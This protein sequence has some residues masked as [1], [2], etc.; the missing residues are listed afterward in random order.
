MTSNAAKIATP[1]IGPKCAY[2]AASRIVFKSGMRALR[3]VNT[4]SL[5]KMKISRV[6]VTNLRAEMLKAIDLKLDHGTIDSRKMIYVKLSNRSIVSDI[7]AAL[8]Y[9]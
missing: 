8:G 4:G 9:F 1:P 6:P 7:L 2:H 3:R 5:R